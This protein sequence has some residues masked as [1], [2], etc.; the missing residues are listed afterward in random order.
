ISEPHE[1]GRWP[2]HLVL[3]EEAAVM[4]DEQAGERKSGS[5]AAGV[6]KGMGYHGALGDGG[7]AIEGGGGG[8]SRFFYV[9]KGSR[10]EKDAGL[11]HLPVRS[12]GEATGRNDN[13]AGL[14]CPRAGAGR[15][16][17]AR[18]FHPTVKSIALMQWLC[19]L[20]T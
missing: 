6:R 7:P 9:A 5:R 4:L 18:N 16:G 19:R 15:V 10:A 12:G 11:D 3:D 17:G 13:T 20:I 2:A 8:A 1:A 14:N